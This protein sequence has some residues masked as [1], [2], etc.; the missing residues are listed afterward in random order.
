MKLIDDILFVQSNDSANAVAEYCRGRRFKAIVISKDWSIQNRTHD[1]AMNVIKH[2]GPIRFSNFF[3]GQIN[4]F[5][6]KPCLHCGSNLVDPEGLIIQSEYRP[7][8]L[9][10]GAAALSLDSWNDRSLLKALVEK[11]ISEALKRGWIA[12]QNQLAELIIETIDSR[13]TTK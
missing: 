10:C 13:K 6:P 9:N 3:P 8:C 4:Y 11:A 5:K 1:F 12:P 2:A 7:L